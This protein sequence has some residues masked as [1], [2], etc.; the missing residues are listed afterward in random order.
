MQTLHVVQSSLFYQVISTWKGND[1]TL[2]LGLL[3]TGPC[4]AIRGASVIRRKDQV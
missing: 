4:L 3:V 2:E 1:R